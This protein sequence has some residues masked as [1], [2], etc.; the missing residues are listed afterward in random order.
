M[1]GASAGGELAL[2]LGLRHPDVYGAI[3]CGSPGGGYQPSGTMPSRV[4]RT[5]LVAGTLEPFFLDN[6]TRWATALRDAGAD[7][8]MGERVASHGDAL[9]RAEF[10]LMVAWAFGRRSSSIPEP[11]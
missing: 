6:A 7:V 8:V 11:D 5:Y 9:W 3:L 1:F 2:A 10:P 4:P